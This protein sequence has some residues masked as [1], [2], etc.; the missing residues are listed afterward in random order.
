MSVVKN[1]PA[2]FQTGVY[3]GWAAVETGPIHKMVMSV[4]WNP[5]FDNKEKSMVRISTCLFEYLINK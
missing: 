3:C 1:L 2:D 4:G 5:F